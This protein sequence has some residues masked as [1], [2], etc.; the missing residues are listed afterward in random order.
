MTKACIS[1]SGWMDSCSSTNYLL[2]IIPD[3]L[4]EPSSHVGVAHLN[5]GFLTWSTSPSWRHTWGIW[6]P[7][8]CSWTCTRCSPSI[9]PRKTAWTFASAFT[10]TK[11]ETQAVNGKVSR[12]I[13]RKSQRH[14]GKGDNNATL[15][16][17]SGSASD[18][19][20]SVCASTWPV[21]KQPAAMN[22]NTQELHP[23]TEL[24]FGQTVTQSPRYTTRATA[25]PCGAPLVSHCTKT[26]TP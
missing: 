8:R 2:N 14:K 6:T 21:L 17:V 9:R 4:S 24:F 10:Q 13:R 7:Q 16:G 18:V 23:L 12:F 25:L 15:C 22:C 19:K 5:G 1:V 20:L 11:P 26:L 3:C